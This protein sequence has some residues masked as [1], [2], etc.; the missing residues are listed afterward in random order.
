MRTP[1]Y[2]VEPLYSNPLKWGHLCVQWNPSIPTPWNEDTCGIPLFQPP[3]MR[4]PL[5]TVEPLYSNPLKWG[6]LCVQWNPW[7]GHLLHFAPFFKNISDIVNTSTVT[8]HST[9][10]S[11]VNPTLTT[12][13]SQQR[14]VALPKMTSN[15]ECSTYKT[16]S[17]ENSMTISWR[18][19]RP[20]T[21][22]W[23]DAG[24]M[25]S[26]ITN[27]IPTCKEIMKILRLYFLVLYSG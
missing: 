21:L 20:E 8:I 2:T 13:L 23:F 3:E 10:S 15:W 6:H 1:L 7:L 22:I 27:F 26:S 4:T 5:C 24:W 19:G 14:A 12:P 9:L 16:R 18:R 25:W 17:N 11:T